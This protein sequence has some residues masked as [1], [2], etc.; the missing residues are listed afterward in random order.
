M[1]Q[2]ILHTILYIYCK[3][4]TFLF[5][6]F[7]IAFHNVCTDLWDYSAR[8]DNFLSAELSLLLFFYDENNCFLIPSSF[9]YNSMYRNILS[10]AHFSSQIEAITRLLVAF[11]SLR[12]VCHHFTT[13][14]LPYFKL[15]GFLNNFA[16]NIC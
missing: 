12:F 15:Y 3:C 8:T 6:Y 14:L 2:H 1:L 9:P 11:N 4:I 16:I 13:I 5:H 7:L 10:V